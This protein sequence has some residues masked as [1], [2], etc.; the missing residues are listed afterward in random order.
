MAELLTRNIKQKFESCLRE[1]NN[2][3][4]MVC[5]FIG[6]HTA[7]LLSEKISELNLK[8]SII[9]KFNRL[10]F[11]NGVSSLKG[12][13]LLNKSGAKIKAIKKLHSKLYIFDS[14]SIIIGSSNFTNGGLITNLE[15]NIF[16]EDSRKIVNQSIAYFNE[17]DV[18]I[19]D[20]FVV[21]QELI[22]EEIGH[23]DLLKSKSVKNPKPKESFGKE[24]SPIRK[25]DNLEQSIEKGLNKTNPTSSAWIKFEGFS[26]ER[27]TKP[28][29]IVNIKLE[30]NNCYKT[31]FPKKP[32]GYKDGDVVFIAR[33]SL[34]KN[35]D[36]SPI[37]FG[38]GITR[39]FEESNVVPIE[40][41]E[42]NE[43]LKRWPYY[44][45]V[46]NLR[47]INGKLSKG[48]PLLDIYREIGHETYPSTIDKEVTFEKLKRIHGQKDK[49]R[50]TNE[51]KEY[52]L[53]KMNE[54][55]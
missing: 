31:R 25:L 52:L 14:R 53:D 3:F 9:T 10:D 6:F 34:T 46:E 16:I 29:E 43:D 23:I 27:R 50:I 11:Y 8:A 47:H 51:A 18:T 30:D 22:N 5:P 38:Y 17:L 24:Y 7:K 12:L 13:S 49:L 42:L 48:I 36:K 41:Q 33:N 26:D 45:Y 2:E 4:R 40:E 55:L 20:K 28:N 54:I 35:G 32:K 19:G 37:I 44:I 39:K 15:L 21:T 1:S